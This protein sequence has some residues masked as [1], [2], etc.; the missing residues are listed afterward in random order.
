MALRVPYAKVLA[1][2]ATTAALAAD[3]LLWF[4]PATALQFGMV[5]TAAAL[6]GTGNFKRESNP[7]FPA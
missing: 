4:I 7:F 6:R 1:A 5:S 3:Y 2:D